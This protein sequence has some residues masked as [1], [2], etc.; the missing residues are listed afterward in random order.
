M[1]HLK[2]KETQKT[3]PLKCERRDSTA[4]F[5]KQ[6]ESGKSAWPD[7]QNGLKPIFSIKTPYFACIEITLKEFDKM[8]KEKNIKLKPKSFKL[9]IN[10][11]YKI[12]DGKKYKLQGT[13]PVSMEYDLIRIYKKH[14]YDVKTEKMEFDKMHLWLRR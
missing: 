7:R 5:T 14:G 4:L 8:R 10:N 3:L 1:V 2:A 13:A 6:K 11:I 9:A 12:F